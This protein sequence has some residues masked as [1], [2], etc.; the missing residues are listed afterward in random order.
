MKNNVSLKITN[1][2]VGGMLRLTLT[3]LLS[4]KPLIGGFQACFL[5]PPN[6]NY[7]LGG[8]VEYIPGK[9]QTKQVDTVFPCIVFAETSFFLA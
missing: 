7:E 9:E 3:P 5:K 8:T 4:S 1:V 6:V 2:Q